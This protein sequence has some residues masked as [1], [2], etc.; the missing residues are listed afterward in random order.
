[1]ISVCSRL[2]FSCAD[3]TGDANAAMVTGWPAADGLQAPGVRKK[4][5]RGAFG[6]RMPRMDSGFDPWRNIQTD[7]RMKAIA[8]HR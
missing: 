8:D 4:F 6:H 5:S 2:S 7:D 1:M 3:V